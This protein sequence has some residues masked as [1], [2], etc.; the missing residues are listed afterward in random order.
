MRILPPLLE[1]ARSADD[2]LTAT[3][4]EVSLIKLSL[5]RAQSEHRFYGHRGTKIQALQQRCQAPQSL[6]SSE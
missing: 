3:T 4:I 1:R 6:H 2:E 5:I